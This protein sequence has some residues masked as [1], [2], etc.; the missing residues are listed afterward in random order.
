MGLLEK[1]AGYVL[2]QSAEKGLHTSCQIER[3]KEYSQFIRFYE[4][5]SRM[6]PFSALEM[7]IASSG[8]NLSREDAVREIE[9]ELG[10]SLQEVKECALMKGY[11]EK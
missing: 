3:C 9:G 8:R 7:A 4:M 1:E 2:P 10:F 11:I 6:I 5:R